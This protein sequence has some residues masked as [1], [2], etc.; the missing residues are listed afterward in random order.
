MAKKHFS[1][2]FW[3][4]DFIQY[5]KTERLNIQS[6][7]VD[8]SVENSLE[9]QINPSE[10]TLVS[11]S[12]I[13][14]RMLLFQADLLPKNVSVG[15]YQSEKG[16]FK[17]LGFLDAEHTSLFIPSSIHLIKLVGYGSNDTVFQIS[18]VSMPS[19]Y[20]EYINLSSTTKGNLNCALASHK[21][22]DSGGYS[23]NYGNNE[24]NSMTFCNPDPTRSVQLTF[25]P[26]PNPDRQLQLNSST[27]G[28]D[29]LYIFNGN[30]T[31]SNLVGTYTGSTNAAP[32][33]GS[34]VSTENC[35]T[36]RMTT[37]S[38]YTDAGFTAR[39]YCVDKPTIQPTVYVGGVAGDKTFQDD[40][41]VSG[42]YSN[43]Q[44]YIQTYCPDQT[45]TSGESVWAEF[46]GKAGL[47]KNWDYMY[48]FDGKSPVNSKLL[49]VYTGDNNNENELKT[50]KSSVE[51]T[52]GCLTF[53]FF[54]DGSTTASGWFATVYTDTPRLAFGGESCMTATPITEPFVDY[55][56][57]TLNH[58]GT[59]GTD[60]PALHV[61]ISSLAECSGTNTITRFENST[62]FKFST[63]DSICVAE[64]FELVF[65]NVSCQGQGT[66]GT[67]LQFLL[68]EASSCFVGNM[69]PSPVYCSDKVLDGSQIDVKNY[70]K[71]N[72]SY[73]VMI[74]GF[75]GQNCNFDLR[76]NME[77]VQDSINCALP[78][79]WLG[80]TG[81]A[82]NK[83]NV[84]QWQT[85]NEENVSHFIVERASDDNVSFQPITW[86]DA[87]GNNS[88]DIQYYTFEDYD[89][90]TGTSY[91]YRV[92]QIDENGSYSMSNMIHIDRVST[93]DP[94]TANVYPN[95]FTDDVSIHIPTTVETGFFSVFDALGNQVYVENLDH[96]NQENVQVDLSSLISGTYF[97]VL[98]FNSATKTGYMIKN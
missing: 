76:L 64:T 2:K 18:A 54:S 45:A 49:C 7:F 77:M 44:S 43:N 83:H 39:L 19:T 88:M 47:E 61:S 20:S 52:T 22:Y 21:L 23:G 62:W 81:S 30:D 72:T 84:L 26:N 66:L 32:Q 58:T 90:Q 13:T 34:F 53:Q 87:T 67:G 50:I 9:I 59:P 71:P 6:V 40:G 41:G 1:S 27:I 65:S 28:N 78:L 96:F 31:S 12:E 38:Q 85:A 98:T 46:I 51:N 56:G 37:N 25:M 74:D 3:N 14:D 80:F 16:L 79:D 95:P 93:N 86:L 24:D 48:V 15:V 73:F 17:L 8:M 57:T 70:I 10:S 89:V 29:Y 82:Q 69:W 97:Y 75:T 5:F 68:Y 94:F 60:D 91:Y 33:P 36:L 42:N 4:D 55:T 11:T 92:R 63:P 35:L